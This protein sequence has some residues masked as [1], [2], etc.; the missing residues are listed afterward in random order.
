MKS[1]I[2]LETFNWSRGENGDIDLVAAGRM[3]LET[4]LMRM[5]DLLLL[6]SG[7]Y[8]RS[9]LENKVLSSGGE[10]FF[11]AALFTYSIFSF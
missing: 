6:L 4:G 11:L 1:V 10:W 8:F 7:R 5:G 3:Y 2:S 9:K